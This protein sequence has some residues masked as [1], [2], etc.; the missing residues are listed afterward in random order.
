MALGDEG[1]PG[2][3]E[4]DLVA[5][6]EFR[7]LEL[8]AEYQFLLENNQK[9][10][11]KFSSSISYTP[12]F[13]QLFVITLLTLICIQ[14]FYLQQRILSMTKKN[15][16]EY[17]HIYS[18]LWKYSIELEASNFLEKLEAYPRKSPRFSAI[19][20]LFSFCKGV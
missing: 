3:F 6:E 4:A 17:N 12:M 15:F 5:E 13:F 10:E 7:N 14:R 8:E 16:T 18:V 11:D 1:A 20:F 2:P 19:L 9:L